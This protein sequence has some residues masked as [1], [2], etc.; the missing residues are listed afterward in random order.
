MLRAVYDPMRLDLTDFLAHA[1]RRFPVHLETASPSSSSDAF[2]TL[3]LLRIEG[4]AFIQ[5]GT[6]YLEATIHAEWEQACSRCLIPVPRSLDLQEI[7]EMSIPPGADSLD[8]YPEVSDL[9]LSAVDPNTLCRPECRG[10][11]P[12]C[13][14]DLN[15]SP[16]H[17]CGEPENERR[18][19]RD[20]LT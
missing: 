16:D 15:E 7:F 12:V 17:R 19:L 10:L 1:G 18:T 5:L 3:V 13:G 11:C 2:V 4:E 20:F 9:V 14:A 6:L 8:L